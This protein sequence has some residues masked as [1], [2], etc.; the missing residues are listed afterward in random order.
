[1]KR[2][3]KEPKINNYKIAALGEFLMNYESDLVYIQEFQEIFKNPKIDIDFV[4]NKDGIFHQFLIEFKIARNFKKG[5]QKDVFLLCRN[6]INKNKNN[7][8]P[9]KL[10]DQFKNKK[11][12]GKRL[13]SLSSKVIAFYDSENYIPMDSLNRKAINSKIYTYKNFNLAVEEMKKDSNFMLQIKQMDAIVAP[14]V[15]DFEHLSGLK[16]YNFKKIRQN[17]LIDKLLRIQH[18]L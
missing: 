2:I 8:S 11:S 18:K 13:L 9:D 4:C 15:K 1:M 6:Y 16:G 10:S 5:L 17:R 3:I 14:L 12:I 7:L